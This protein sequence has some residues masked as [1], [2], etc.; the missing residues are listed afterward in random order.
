M[1]HGSLNLA[2]ETNL[3]RFADVRLLQDRVDGVREIIDSGNLRE[4]YDEAKA[5]V[6]RAHLMMV[7]TESPRIELDLEEIIHSLLREILGVG[8]LREYEQ[9]VQQVEL[10]DDFDFSEVE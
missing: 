2:S 1:S 10:I 8:S 3:V 9:E 6:S 4:A 5:V 7:M